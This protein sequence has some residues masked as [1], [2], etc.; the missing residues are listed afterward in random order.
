MLCLFV[1]FSV[2]FPWS[3]N[4]NL[5]MIMGIWPSLGCL[6]MW[7]CL[8]DLVCTLHVVC[9]ATTAV[10]QHKYSVY[11][12]LLLFVLQLYNNT[13]SATHL[14]PRRK[15]RPLFYQLL[16]QSVCDLEVL[17]YNPDLNNSVCLK[18]ICGEWNGRIEEWSSPA[19]CCSPLI[20]TGSLGKKRLDLVTGSTQ[21]HGKDS[22]EV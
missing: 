9:W 19:L 15:P 16:I 11:K 10:A 4:T 1:Y 3:V 14:R 17:S 13:V 18:D 6:L 5:Q 22:P 12:E 8:D 20:K 2:H 21:G 7:S